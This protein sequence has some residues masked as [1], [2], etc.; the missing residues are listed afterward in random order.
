MGY[1]STTATYGRGLGIAVGTGMSTEIGAIAGMLSESVEEL[2]PL[3]KKLDDF[4]KKLGAAI[5]ALCAIMFVVEIG[6]AW[7]RVGHFPA[8]RDVV[9]FFLEAVSLAVAAIPE[10]LAAIVTIVLA[11][12]MQKMVSRNAIIRKLPAV[13]TLGSVNVICSDKTGTLTQN[14]MTVLRAA[15]GGAAG[16][17]VGAE[18]GDSPS[19]LAPEGNEA[20]RLLLEALVLCNDASISTEGSTGD[21][22]E[23]ALVQLGSRYGLSKMELELAHPRIGELPFDSDR[24]L[25]TTVHSYEGASLAMTKGATD[26]LVKRCSAVLLGGAVLPMDAAQRERILGEADAMSRDALRVLGAAYKRF[27]SGPVSG[28][29]LEKDLVFLGL[30]GMIDPPRLEVKD[31]I[32]LCKASG[33]STVMIT[34]DHRNTA[35]AIAKELGIAEREDQVLSGSDLDAMGETELSAATERV[36]VFARVSPE[37]KVRIVKAFR[38]R[39]NIVSMTGDGVNDAPS[40]KAADIGV[41]MGITGTDVAKG[42]ADMVLTDD[43]FKTIVSA[44]GEGRNI[45]ANIRKAILFLLSCNSGEIIAIFGAIVVGWVP[46]LLPIHIL[47]VNLI[48]DVLPALALGMDP[49]DPEVMKAKPRNPNESLFSNGGGLFTVLN[50]AL[51]GLATLAAYQIGEALYPLADPLATNARAQTMAF[52]V[53]SVSQLVHAFNLRHREKSLFQIGPFT[54]KYLVGAFFAGVALQN[55]VIF[56]PGLARIFKVTPLSLTDWGIVSL[57]ALLPLTANELAKLV[58]KLRRII[59]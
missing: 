59:L 28:S 9:E 49:G 40:L 53:L 23:V 13:E 48:T 46:P 31:S 10:G 5:L 45:Y 16:P 54:N 22:T 51:I 20:H 1:L 24:K 58:R 47:W 39:G 14:R 11:I 38:S 36:R 50:G 41:A 29:E 56:V 42:A 18:A 15:C 17:V 37:H 44:I 6:T 57:F 3:Q 12:G 4:G 21:P 27:P 7:T 35:L 8:G 55:A 30:V 43:N 2:T 32:A 26:E 33:I 19:V 52:V 25:M 34:G